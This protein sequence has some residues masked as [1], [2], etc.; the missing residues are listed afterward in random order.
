MCFHARRHWLFQHKWQ[1]H[2]VLRLRRH[3]GCTFEFTSSAFVWVLF[4]CN[5]LLTELGKMRHPS[6][7]IHIEK[8]RYIV[9]EL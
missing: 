1:R 4:G 9:T 3:K 5:Q 7:A 6:L 8:T 2:S